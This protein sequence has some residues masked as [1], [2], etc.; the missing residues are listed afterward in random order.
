LE[1]AQEGRKKEDD[2]DLAL[3]TKNE[4]AA[5]SLESGFLRAMQN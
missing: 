3:R 1:L 5:M 2:R 4:A